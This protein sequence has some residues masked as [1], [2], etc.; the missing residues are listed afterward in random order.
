[1][2]TPGPTE[3]GATLR[4]FVA[5]AHA[6]GWRYAMAPS[7]RRS[8]ERFL[9]SRGVQQ[10][11]EVDTP[12]LLAYQRQLLSCRTASTVAGHI[13]FLRALW[14]FLLREGLVERDV[15]RGV[16]RLPVDHFVP[17]LYSSEELT[18]IEQASCGALARAHTP[19]RR[20]GMWT[21]HAAFCLIRDAG[22]RVSEACHLDLDHYDHRARTLRIERT[23]FFK[24]RL[25][26]LPRSTCRR[27][28]RYL[29]Y[30]LQ[31]HARDDASAAA[32]F[33]TTFRHRPKRSAL[34]DAF[35]QL[36]CHQGLYRPRRR[37]G[38]TVFGSTN[39]HALRHSM[40]VRTLERWQRQRDDVDHL[41]PLLSGYLGHVKVAYTTTY[42]HLTPTLRRL[43]SERLGDR[44]LPRLDHVRDPQ[45]DDGDEHR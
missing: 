5:W 8:F 43:A 2:K 39:L 17:H 41:L 45:E 18:R 23:K 40:A 35:K 32:L 24:T 11:A 29:E 1:M 14:R 34:E 37:R 13:G 27:L 15:T 7:Y 42:L 25:I 4:R 16:P 28:E 6:Q 30:R 22:L 33:L 10:L 26:P 20:L 12:L 31:F 19:A 36:L 9:H 44:V 3:P 38:R 21:R